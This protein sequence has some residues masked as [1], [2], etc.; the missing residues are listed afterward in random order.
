[1]RERTGRASIGDWTHVQTTIVFATAATLERT[2]GFI[3]PSNHK[4]EAICCEVAFSMLAHDRG[5]P[6]VQLR[7]LPFEY[8]SHPQWTSLRSEMKKPIGRLKRVVNMML[9]VLKMRTT[10]SALN[11]A[12][13]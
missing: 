12:R 4:L 10:S 2:G 13:V 9:W 5:F 11:S 3:V 7:F 1:M 8:I 6:A